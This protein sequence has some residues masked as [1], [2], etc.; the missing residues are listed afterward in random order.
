MA[1]WR[2]NSGEGWDAERK[3]W[4]GTAT[5][6]EWTAATRRWRE[7]GATWIGGC[8]RTTPGTIREIATVLRGS[9]E[10]PLLGGW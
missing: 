10:Q 7:L 9:G 3:T 5:P 1:D 2:P 8:C 6:F 4:F